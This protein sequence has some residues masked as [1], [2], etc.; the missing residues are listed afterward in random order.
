MLVPVALILATAGV[1]RVVLQTTSKYVLLNKTKIN[2][3][4]NNQVCV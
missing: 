1:N 3:P 4:T 2:Y